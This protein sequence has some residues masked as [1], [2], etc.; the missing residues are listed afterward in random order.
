MSDKDCIYLDYAATTPVDPEAAAEMCKCLTREGV[1]ANPSSLHGP[2]RAAGR[3]VEAARRKV[4]A[5]FNCRPEEI[6]WTSGATESDNMGLIGVAC[7]NCDRGKHIITSRTEHKAVLDTCAWLE[8]EGFDVTYL[9]PGR[10]GEV[11]ADQVAAAIRSDT[12][13]VSLMHVNNE[14]G[15]IQDIAAIG[16][17]CHDNCVL[18]HVDAAQSAGKLPIDLGALPVDLMSIS[19][20]KFYGPKGVGVLFV[21]SEPRCNLAPVVHGGGQERGLRPGTL[22]THQIVGLATALEIAAGH[23]EAEAARITAL[24]EK[25][26]T[27]LSELGGVHLNGHPERRAPGI[28]NVSFEGVEG[29]SLLF[30]LRELAV[31]SGSACSSSS[32]EG[33]YVLRALG[34]DDQMAQSSIRFSIGRFTTEDEISRALAIVSQKLGRLREVSGW[35]QNATVDGRNRSGAG[36]G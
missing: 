26:W 6:I 25:L 32:G 13:L 22:A 24:R 2:G 33:S 19:G 27:G 10:D 1:F 23:L 17:V 7:Y 15:V 9:V 4:A 16:A 3:V 34:R 28:L 14:I 21:R 12:I 30:M 8:K 11:T 18:F 36:V 29:E 5:V 20:H 31:S 35:T